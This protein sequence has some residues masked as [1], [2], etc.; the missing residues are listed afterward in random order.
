[1]FAAFDLVFL[2]RSRSEFEIWVILKAASNVALDGSAP[3][4]IEC[5]MET[6]LFSDI[7]CAG[8]THSVGEIHFDA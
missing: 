8:E 2:V 4:V 5:T 6:I 3:C 1:M 7:F